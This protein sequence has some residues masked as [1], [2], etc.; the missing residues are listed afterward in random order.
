MPYRVKSNGSGVASA[1]AKRKVGGRQVRRVTELSN[2]RRFPNDEVVEA[3]DGLCTANDDSCRARKAKGTE[4]CIGHLRSM[5]KQS[6][7]QSEQDELGVTDEAAA[8][9]GSDSDAD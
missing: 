6:G 4:F 5:E 7:E 3:R 8:V 2:V 1:N 9:E